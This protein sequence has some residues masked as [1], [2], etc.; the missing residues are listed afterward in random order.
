P[1]RTWHGESLS[2]ADAG[3]RSSREVK[4]QAVEIPARHLIA[5]ALGVRLRPLAGFAPPYRVAGGIKEARG[6]DR[7]LNPKELKNLSSTWRQAFGKTMA[8][9]PTGQ[10]DHRIT[11]LRKQARGG[12][13]RW[14][15]ADYD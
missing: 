6:V 3:A 14:T 15:A 1:R 2:Y 13:T 7:I 9:R 11:P 12:G 4:Q 8:G 5:A 10:D